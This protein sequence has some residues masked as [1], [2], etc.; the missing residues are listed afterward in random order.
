MISKRVLDPSVPMSRLAEHPNVRSIYLRLGISTREAKMHQG[1]EG[2]VRF[3]AGSV[4]R[5]L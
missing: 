4:R 2:A 3:R 1:G 5:T